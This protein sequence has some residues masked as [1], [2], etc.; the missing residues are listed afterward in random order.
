ML[1]AVIAP[2]PAGALAAWVGARVL[3]ALGPAPPPGWIPL[4]IGA[5]AAVIVACVAASWL[6]HP[7]Q[8]LSAFSTAQQRARREVLQPP[9][10]PA[11]ARP[12]GQALVAQARERLSLEEDQQGSISQATQALRAQSDQLRA[13]LRHALSRAEDGNRALRHQATL[14]ASLSH[15][16][17]TPL[18]AIL[19]HAEELSR[20]LGERDTHGHADALHRCASG[21]LGTI[22]DLLDWSRIEAG[23]LTLNEVSF[24]LVDTVEDALALMAPEAYARGL[25]LV[26]FIYHDVPTRLRGDPARLQQIMTNLLSNAIKYTD[27]GEVVMRLMKHDEDAQTVQLRLAVSDTGIGIDPRQIP[28]L[29]DTYS[30]AADGRPGHST[31]LGLSIV[32]QLARAMGGDVEVESTPGVGST[33]T[34][35]LRLQRARDSSPAPPQH[36]LRGSQAWVVEAHAE[37]RL[38]LTHCLD[39]WGVIWRAWDSVDA[40]AAALADTDDPPAFVLLG[41]SVESLSERSVLAL[42]EAPRRSTAVVLLLAG[43]SHAEL[44]QAE[45]LGAELVLPKASGRSALYRGLCALALGQG[46]APLAHRR[47]LIV[48]NTAATRALLQQMLR[49]AGATVEVAAGGEEALHAHAR[50]R[51]DLALVDRQMPGMDGLEVLRHLRASDTPEQR[52]IL[53]LMSAWLEGDAHR[54]AVLAGADIVLPKPFEAR[55]LLRSLAPWLRQS[56][57]RKASSEAVVKGIDTKLLQ[58]EELRQLLAEELPTQMAAIETCFAAAD[59]PGLREACHALHGTAAFYQLHQIKREAAALEKRVQ[60]GVR[61]SPSLDLRADIARLRKTVAESL[62]ALERAARAAG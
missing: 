42:L 30:A 57:S 40:L 1:A 24:D 21:L 28:R 6:S 25:E 55:Q 49:D 61:N 44:Q 20:Q 7:W 62:D 4:S 59:A 32:R 54:D 14:L 45:R 11:Y 13:E 46:S 16:L 17:R 29:F 52:V 3:T 31:G 9:S 23:A 56:A 19:G 27:A 12:V 53:I 33:F 35:R 51:F 10:L 60:R 48:E 37:A 22:N 34:V 18:T 36:S 2:L 43:S 50:E 26:H 8:S 15:E 38:A 5:V 47:V 41:V 39:Y 58:D